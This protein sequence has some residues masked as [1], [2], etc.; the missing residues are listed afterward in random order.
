MNRICYE[1]DCP[2]KTTAPPDRCPKCD[3]DTYTSGGSVPNEKGHACFCTG[4]RIGEPFCP[5]EM[6]SRGI[7]KRDG[8]WVQPERI[9]REITYD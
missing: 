6:R 3:P 4:P 8:H 1:F 9:I 5:C 7:F 2:M